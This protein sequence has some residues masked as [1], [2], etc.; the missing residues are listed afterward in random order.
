MEVWLPYVKGLREA[1]G[2]EGGAY[3][4]ERGPQKE[5]LLP[6]LDAH[7]INAQYDGGLLDGGGGRDPGEGL[8]RPTRKDDDPGA[9]PP[10]AEH[11]RQ[12]LLLVHLHN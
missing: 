1:E 2:V 6:L 5:L 4:R 10:V 12:R 9:G 8:P 11:L 7:G 3:Y